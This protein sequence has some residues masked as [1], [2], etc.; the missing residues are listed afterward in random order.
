MKAVKY[1]FSLVVTISFLAQRTQAQPAQCSVSIAAS[2]T[3]IY[4]GQSVDMTAYGQGANV[5]LSNDFNDGTVGT[6]WS[7]TQS[8][9]FTNPCSPS[10]VDGTIHLWMGDASP[11]PR[12]LTTVPFDLTPGGTICFDMMYATQGGAAPCEGPDLS[13]EGVHLQYSTDGGATWTDIAYFDPNGGY[14]PT[15]TTWNN[16]CFAIPAGALTP[17]TIIQWHQDASSGTCCDHWGIDN[18]EI[19]LNTY[20][21]YYE[22][23]NDMY[24]GQTHPTVTPNS[25]TTFTV[26]YTNG[27]DDSCYASVNINLIEPNITVTASGATTVC[28]GVCVTLTGSGQQEVYQETPTPVTQSVSPGSNIAGGLFSSG[29]TTSTINVSGVG[30]STVS[31]G[32]LQ[33]VCMN[34]SHP[35][36]ADLDIYLTCP[37]GVQLELT[38]GNGGSGDN[39]NL[40]CFDINATTNITSGS[41][42]FNGSFVPEGGSLLAFNG[43]PVNGTWILEVTDNS[44]PDDGTLNSWSLTFMDTVVGYGVQP[45]TDFSWQPTTGM[46]GGTTS[47][48]VVCPTSTTTYT[49]TATANH[50]CNSDQAS[51]TVVVTTPF[52]VSSS[53]TPANCTSADG[54]VDITVSSG[55]GNYT[56]Q[57]STGA[58]TE[59]LSNVPFGNYFVTITDNTL[60][61]SDIISFTVPSNS[62]ISITGFSAQDVS[63]NGGS[64][65]E[66]TVNVSGS[67]APFTFQWD[68]AAGNQTGNPATGLSAGT[69][70]VTVTDNFGC[71][72][73]GSYSVSEPSA[74]N[75]ST[76]FT[77]VTCNGNNDGT[78]SV[79]AGGG[80]SPYNYTWNN[81]SNSSAIT[82]L[83][84]GVYS[85]TVTDFNGCEASSSGSVIEPPA[86]S[87]TVTNTNV[88]CNGFCDGTA[89]VNVQGGLTPYSYQWDDPLNQTS[90]NLT[91]LCADTLRVT[92]TDAVGCVQIDSI[93]ILQPAGMLYNTSFT[94][95]TCSSSNGSATIYGVSNGTPP[96][97]YS[98]NTGETTPNISGLSAGVYTYTITDD[99]SCTKT[100]AITVTD[101]PSPVF[102]YTVADVLCNG[103]S[104]GSINVSVSGGEIPY[105]YSWSSGETVEDVSSLAAGNYSLTVTDVNNCTVSGGISVSEP[106]VLSVTISSYSDASLPG[107][108]DGS[109]TASANGGTPSYNYQW[110][111]PFNQT[112]ATANNLPAGTYT[113]TV[114]DANG[115]Q[116]TTSVTITEPGNFTVVAM[117]TDPLCNGGQGSAVANV[118]GGLSPYVYVW[119][120][121]NSVNIGAVNSPSVSG[122]MPGVYFVEVTDANGVT[123]SSNFITISEPSAISVS[124]LSSRDALCYGSSDGQATLSVTG[125]TSPYLFSWNN[126]ETGPS[127][128]SLPAGNY[129]ITVMDDHGCNE[130]FSVNI[131]QPTAIT[132]YIT[133][134]DPLCFEGTDGQA[135]VFVSGGTSPYSYYWENGQNGIT[136]TGLSAGITMVTVT[137]A[138]GCQHITQTSLTD[139]PILI[140]NITS[141]TEPSCFGFNDG[142]IFTDH[143]GGTMPYS[144][145]WSNGATTQNLF[146]APSGLYNLTITDANGCKNTLSQWLNNPAQ[147][148]GSIVTQDESC[149]EACNGQA[150]ALP[151]GGT[152][153]Y[154]YQWNADGLFQTGAMA[155]NL[156]TG[157]PE[158]TVT[159]NNGCTI[160]LNG[161][162]SGPPKIL[163]NV[164]TTDANCG[165]SNGSIQ[166]NVSGGVSPYTYLWNDPQGQT[167]SFA[168][169]LYAGCYN[170]YVTD[171]SNCL[172]DSTICINDIEGPTVN[173]TGV[174][175]V[176]CF[177]YSDGYININIQG[178]VN[179]YTISWTNETENTPLP[180]FNNLQA[181]FNLES[182]VYSAVVTD[183]A[184]CIASVSQ[185]I[186]QPDSIITF[187]SSTPVS[188]NGGNDGTAKVLV[189]LGTPPYTYLWDDSQNQTTVQATGLTAGTYTVIITDNNN[190][191]Q[192]VDVVVTEPTPIEASLNA[193]DVNC[194]G[195]CDGSVVANVS[196][197]TPPYNYYWSPSLN[198]NASN[199]NL[200]AGSYFLTVEDANLCSTTLSTTVN[201]PPLLTAQISMTPSTCSS[202]NGTATVYNVSGG[203]PPYTYQWTNTTL[204]TTPTLTGVFSGYYCVEVQDAG[205][206]QINLCVSVTDLPS[207][208]ITDITVTKP[209][210]Y[211]QSN[212]TATVLVQPGG[213][214]VINYQWNDPLNQ[215]TQTASDLEGNTIYTVTV[216]DANGC[217][218]VMSKFVGEPPVLNTIGDYLSLCYGQTGTFWGLGSGGT[219]PLSISWAGN[220]AWDNIFG[221]HTLLFYNDTIFQFTI[222]D[223]KGC[224][225]T[226]SVVVEVS[227]ALE[228]VT[229]S[230]DSICLGDNVI[231]TAS[232]SGGL[233]V[234]SYVYTWFGDNTTRTDVG[235]ATSTQTFSP[236]A[237]DSYFVSLT[238]G[239]SEPVMKE[240]PVVVMPL[241]SPA[242][243]PFLNAGCP[244]HT[245]PI[246]SQQGAVDIVLYKW[247]F[248]G[249][250]I[251]DTASASN[252]MEWTYE[253]TGIYDIVVTAVSDFG[254]E[255]TIIQPQAITV[256]PKPDVVFKSN[257]D[258]YALITGPYFEFDARETVDI[259]D[260]LYLSWEFGDGFGDKNIYQTSHTYNDTGFYTVSLVGINEFN[261]IDTA[262]KTIEVKPDVALYIPNAFTPNNDGI[263]DTFF[264]EGVGID[265]RDGEFT[266]YVFDRWG[267]LIF[268]SQSRNNPWDGIAH[269]KGGSKIVQSGVYVWKIEATTYEGR[270]INKKTKLPLSGQVVLLK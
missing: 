100:G 21:Y 77:N 177:G 183:N 228:L 122:L 231:L 161:V 11:D 200:C 12:D 164:T 133:A 123:N 5:L 145:L 74:L 103:Q 9:T 179:P 73:A 170:A 29:T 16:Y 202:D 147:L 234:S 85:V 75:I 208:N 237:S 6:G 52:T 69:Y 56:Y 67:G 175:D 13:D 230:Y 205:N 94:D 251:Q 181:V 258:E 40:T 50:N 91:G 168:T 26:L 58:T 216:T 152:P 102:T 235:V 37:S 55:S 250:G 263:N 169:G 142:M 182:A 113:V 198:N 149:F 24:V 124:L 253:N 220:S 261:C 192:A 44:W 97:S 23:Q 217:T 70:F 240:I 96:Y 212:G 256:Y 30:V 80:T 127:S 78:G 18:V 257:P 27:V 213:S 207:P 223:S 79:V 254:C 93:K 32:V 36:D 186:D 157:N 239:C 176:S 172:Q 71:K 185:L 204:E 159:D 92:I 132:S 209:L 196:G 163:I 148:T 191:Q 126:G 63:C 227:P 242:I 99:N 54:A 46:T 153:P 264:P 141:V 210:C 131:N 120:D 104:N 98:W 35:Y 76:T 193:Y 184:G 199:F 224:Y 59:D 269:E 15:L 238:D 7:S 219:P 265:W 61:C 90:P 165:Q 119:Y 48:P 229:T 105:S 107:A 218:D 72:T 139:P 20:P 260:T 215:Q 143:T 266:F 248:D 110:N 62:D 252:L 81:G 66:I 214:S 140:S 28:P 84:A 241:P 116:A 121:D 42:P 38:T 41:P 190:C 64:D 130:Y 226:D 174:Q 188:C 189:A 118:M 255:N 194:F 108:S 244:P 125:G 115:C 150:T 146:N 89:S 45:V 1:I 151:S 171:N 65:G 173:V 109:A 10:G 88:S 3:N 14:D 187:P 262:T 95:E 87:S 17:N 25:D 137:D 156:C 106:P 222:T 22:W 180:A 129:F 259:T 206:C 195:A 166:I 225:K 160:V 243:Y 167:T 111:D 112:S 144:F 211:G 158:V 236:A 197:G 249:D 155:T 8:A 86:M 245:T 203:K 2:S 57:W 60:G 49:L 270:K 33:S 135:S 82:G 83:S 68:A 246:S 247:D 232:A 128:T 221:P 268:K 267:E 101:H 31:T 19:I 134:T 154:S 136:A 117:G 233:G 51:V 4:C 114:T 34:I 53:I 178:G 162:I 201:E 39:Y 138:N 43:C 47:N